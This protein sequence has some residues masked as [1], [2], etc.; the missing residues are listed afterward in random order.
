MLVVRDLPLE[1]ASLVVR[2]EAT[3]VE[4]TRR[5]KD[6]VFFLGVF[7]RGFLFHPSLPPP[8]VTPLLHPFNVLGQSFH[9]VVPSVHVWEVIVEP[10]VF[11][12]KWGRFGQLLFTD[13]GDDLLLPLR[14]RLILNLFAVELHLFII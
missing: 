11:K 9:L 12:Q 13:V 2:C 14:H 4:L 8:L 6:D 10:H 7:V 5:R 3:S 1:T